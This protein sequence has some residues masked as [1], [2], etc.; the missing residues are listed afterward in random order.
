LYYRRWKPYVSAAERRSNAEREINKLR[1][2][3]YD[4]SPVVIEDRAIAHTF[5]GKAWCDNLDH[6]SD[7][8][9]RLPRGRT[10]VRNGYL[11]DLHIEP[12]KLK[13]LVSG[14]KIYKVTVNVAHLSNTK[15]KS[16]CADC[17]GGID[18]LVELLQ[19]RFSKGVMERICKRKTGLFPAPA[20][21]KFSCTCPDWAY[22]C[23]HVAAVLLG[24][25]A[26]L[27]AQPELLFRLRKVSEAELIVKAGR[28]LPL[29]KKTPAADK[30]LAPDCLSEIFGLEMADGGEERPDK[31][32]R[33][34]ATSAR[35]RRTKKTNI[36]VENPTPKRRPKKPPQKTSL[37]T[38]KKTSKVPSK[39][40]AKRRK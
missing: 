34:S 23:K 39:P 38:G 3:G 2:K 11:L 19:G 21:M 9:N 17:A 8:K 5:W 4:V 36:P 13:A 6:Y 30:L 20:E 1:K 26:R 27:D 31:A 18:S 37:P 7:F 14:S 10:Y 40:K 16:I 22:M 24:F 25:G 32:K 33:T 35:S 29:T 15:W 28:G 12:G